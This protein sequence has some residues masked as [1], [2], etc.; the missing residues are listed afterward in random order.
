VTSAP[1]LLQLV[2][3]FWG[4]AVLAGLCGY[5]LVAALEADETAPPSR[6][7][8]LSLLPGATSTPLPTPLGGYPTPSPLTLFLACDSRDS[9]V[10]PYVLTP[11][12]YVV[13]RVDNDRDL[14]TELVAGR[15]TRFGTKINIVQTPCM[16][17]LLR[18]GQFP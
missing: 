9:N 17:D 15:S 8:S 18:N 12:G 5:S 3:L 10:A 2:R 11:G 1:G 6:G 14:I 13:L 7:Q 4:V 16:R